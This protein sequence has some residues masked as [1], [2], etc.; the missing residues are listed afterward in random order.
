MIYAKGKINNNFTPQKVL[1]KVFIP[2]VFSLMYILPLQEITLLA[3][4]V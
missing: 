1:Y 3:N 2:T 4:Y